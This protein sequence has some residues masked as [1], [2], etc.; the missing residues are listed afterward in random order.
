MI[1]SNELLLNGEAC[2]R[3][4]QSFFLL[5]NQRT[6]SKEINLTVQFASRSQSSF[7]RIIFQT[8]V[9][10]PVAIPLFNT[11]RIH[12]S[13][14]SIC[15]SAIFSSIHHSVVNLYGVGIGNMQF[16]AWEQTEMK[17]NNNLKHRTVAV[18][19]FSDGGNPHSSTGSPLNFHQLMSRKRET[20]V[21][22]VA[23]R[24]QLLQQIATEI[25]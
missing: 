5:F 17:L 6:P 15:N 13:V 16:P 23:A 14:S 8:Q 18:T 12:S 25:Q 24:A 7:Q 21:A 22:E 2:D 11:H 4:L 19:H 3:F 20:L 10:V 9:C 1:L